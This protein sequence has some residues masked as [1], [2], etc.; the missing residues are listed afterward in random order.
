MKEHRHLGRHPRSAGTEPPQRAHPRQVRERRQIR[1]PPQAPHGKG[2]LTVN[3]RKLFDALGALKREAD[4]FIFQNARLL[5]NEP[6]ARKEIQRIVYEQL[7]NRQGLALTPAD[8]RL[9]NDMVLSEYL[10]EYKGGMPA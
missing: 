8:L 6:F 9:I 2:E 1:P 10:Q 5:Q 3:E 4:Q 7:E